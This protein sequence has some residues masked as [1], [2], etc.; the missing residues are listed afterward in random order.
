MTETSYIG[1]ERAERHLYRSE[2]RKSIEVALG[3]I[4]SSR[5]RAKKPLD[6]NEARKSM[7]TA[8]GALDTIRL[9]TADRVDYTLT[10]RKK[11]ERAGFSDLVVKAEIKVM[12]YATK[13]LNAQAENPNYA[14]R[15][16]YA[17]D[18]FGIANG[19]DFDPLRIDAG[20]RGLK[21]AEKKGRGEYFS[22]RIRESL[23]NPGTERA[24]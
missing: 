11:A 23:K 15:M 3:A 20:D 22:Q 18:L 10:L 17:L 4:D 16:Q 8:L 12:Q 5:I 24:N 13:G 6:E 7:E 21:W 1:T 14:Q 19:H 9:S 2:A